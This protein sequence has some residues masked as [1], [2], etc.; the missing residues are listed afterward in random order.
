MGKQKTIRDVAELAGVSV[1]TASRVLNDADYPVRQQ[2]KQR[3]RDA[4]EKLNY[5]PNAVARSLRQDSCKDIGLIVPNISNPFYLQAIHGIEDALRTSDYNIILCNTMHDPERE[6]AFLKQL[7]ERQVK[8]VIL[9]SVGE[10]NADIVQMHSKRGMKFVLLDQILTGVETMCI[11]FDSKAGARMAVEY[12]IQQGHQKIAFA[13]TPMI[14]WT[15]REMYKGYQDALLTAG[16]P[17]DAA[18]VFEYSQGLEMINEGD[19]LNIGRSIADSFIR[20]GC[21]ATAI[22]CVNDMVAIG[23]IQ[24]LARQGIRVPADV[25]V[26]GFDN[27]PFAEAYLPS[28]TT[29]HYPA[30]EIGRLAAIMLVDSIQNNTPKQS[31]SMNLAPRLV[32]R[33][34]VLPPR[35][36][37]IF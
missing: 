5:S 26:I 9:S 21:P 6:K 23:C 19:E 3:V 11:N 17:L 15:R 1:A 27:I 22:L 31:L 33:D 30:Q 12:L 18:L 8:G 29:V 10:V 36:I 13:T 16:I 7:Y 32:I 14:R 4:A 35:K 28:L 34:T 2:L 37:H 20:R 25:S 24:T